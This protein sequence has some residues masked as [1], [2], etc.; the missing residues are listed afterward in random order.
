MLDYSNISMEYKSNS[1]IENY[2]KRLKLKLSNYLYGKKNQ[3]T[4]PIFNYF[5]KEEEEEYRLDI[6]TN[7]SKL[8][9]KAL[10]KSENYKDKD[11]LLRNINIINKEKYNRKW[12]VYNNFSCRY[13]C[14]CNIFILL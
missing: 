6:I 5:I 12:L 10:N 4:W 2:N 3:I 11:D 8:E 1:Y 13:D 9:K 14:F 7:E